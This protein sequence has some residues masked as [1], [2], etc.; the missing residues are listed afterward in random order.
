[1]TI[2]NSTIARIAGNI[3]GTILQQPN[4][5]SYGEDALTV[6]AKA[7][8]YIARAIVAEVERTAK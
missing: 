7:S 4:D 5:P 8:V 1:M 6:A 2:N 3:V